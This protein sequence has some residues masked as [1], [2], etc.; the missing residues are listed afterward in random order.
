MIQYKIKLNSGMV[1][2]TILVERF[3]IE[4]GTVQE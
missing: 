4:I 2:D 3:W 1:N